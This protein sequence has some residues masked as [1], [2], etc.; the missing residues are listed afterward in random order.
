MNS[1]LNWFAM[2][3]YALYIWSVYGLV[4]IVLMMNGLGIKW[5]RHRTRKTLRQWFQGQ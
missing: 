5:Q 3:G 1:F 4:A 2:G